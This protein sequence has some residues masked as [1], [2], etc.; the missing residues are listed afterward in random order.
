MNDKELEALKALIEAKRID[1]EYALFRIELDAVLVK[2]G[3]RIQVM[4]KGKFKITN[5]FGSVFY[6]SND[7]TGEKKD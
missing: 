5:R 7:L 2:Y 1:A 6:E 4:G 3:M